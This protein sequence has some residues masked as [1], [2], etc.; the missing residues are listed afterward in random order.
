MRLKKRCLTDVRLQPAA[1]KPQ[2]A[3]TPNQ[4]RG[5]GPVIRIIPGQLAATE[6]VSVES[7]RMPEAHIFSTTTI[8]LKGL[9]YHRVVKILVT[10][11]I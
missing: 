7:L 8:F 2:V 10:V 11:A 6:P 5:N 3:L 9:N 4:A 1:Y